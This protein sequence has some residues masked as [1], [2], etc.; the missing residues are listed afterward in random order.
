MAEDT[1]ITS[2]EADTAVTSE[3]EDSDPDREDALHRETEEDEFHFTGRVP[4]V[5]HHTNNNNNN[6]TTGEP[7]TNSMFQRN[8]FLG[9]RPRAITLKASIRG[10]S[11]RYMMNPLTTNCIIFLNHNHRRNMA[12][13]GIT[14]PNRK[15]KLTTMHRS[16]TMSPM[17]ITM[18]QTRDTDG[19]NR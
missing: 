13:K 10:I 19:D 6:I 8:R 9:R 18:N 15:E 12:L 1:S 2:E 11:R 5:E 4:Q 7:L 17:P 16:I 14:K 3:A